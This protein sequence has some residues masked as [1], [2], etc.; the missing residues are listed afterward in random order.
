[1][2]RRSRAVRLDPRPVRHIMRRHLR[3]PVA[4]GGRRVFLSPRPAAVL[5]SPP[6][7]RPCRADDHRRSLSVAPANWLASSFSNTCDR[8]R[9]PPPAA[10]LAMDRVSL[11]QFESPPAPRAKG[12][13]PCGRAPVSQALTRSG[14]LTR[15][16]QRVTAGL[17]S[18][19][20]RGPAARAGRAA[21]NQEMTTHGLTNRPHL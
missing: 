10:R 6:R 3:T 17:G 2:A 4:L 7:S 19:P 14:S 5:L 13:G 18:R 11:P 20:P 8:D 16:A 1:M 15:P 12:R 21:S 9:H